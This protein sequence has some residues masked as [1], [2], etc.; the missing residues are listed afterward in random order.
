M[1]VDSESLEKLKCI[2]AGR[3][4]EMLD[5]IS[6]RIIDHL[7]SDSI[8]GGYK[9]LYDKMSDIEANIETYRDNSDFLKSRFDVD[10]LHRIDSLDSVGS[11]IIDTIKVLRDT[12]HDTPEYKN[13]TAELASLKENYEHKLEEIKQA[14]NSPDR[15]DLSKANENNTDSFEQASYIRQ[16]FELKYE[17]LY[18]EDGTLRISDTSNSES[19]FVELI[20]KE[21]V[22]SPINAEIPAVNDKYNASAIEAKKNLLNLGIRQTEMKRCSFILRS[23]QERYILSMVRELTAKVQFPIQRMRMDAM[24]TKYI[25]MKKSLVIPCLNLVKWG[26]QRKTRY[27]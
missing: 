25:L 13:L 23:K 7:S 3:N 22:S 6:D 17:G 12:D 1:E 11:E 9:A 21:T 10:L 2:L 4:D 26:L 14:A 24:T 20:K 16:D 27:S 8:Q 18:D 15:I 19:R 5:K